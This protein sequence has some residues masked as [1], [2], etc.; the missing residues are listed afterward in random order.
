MSE[1][2]ENFMKAVYQQIYDYHEKAS[3][4]VI[5]EKLNISSS[6]VTDM[7]K[8]LSNK[9][10]IIYEKYKNI[11]LTPQGYEMALRI[12]RRH[13]LWELFLSTVFNLDMSQ[14]HR[15]AELLEHTTSD[16]L[17]DK[18]EEYLGHPY[19][20]PHGDPIPDKNGNFHGEPAESTLL[21]VKPDRKYTIK[22]LNTRS[23]NVLQFLNEYHFSV[24]K[25]VKLMQHIQP[26]NAV[27]VKIDNT[28]IIL[29][30]LI[31]SCVLVVK[32]KK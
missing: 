13:R 21:D 25:P 1:S 26:E 22:R 16:F 9:Q 6:A 8:K 5:A 31:A 18:L 7:S 29:N 23:E 15:E 10:L 20:D 3:T 28:K 12:V 11:T 27:L 32:A 14:I 30:A 24:N 17:T 19:S 4:S 2:V